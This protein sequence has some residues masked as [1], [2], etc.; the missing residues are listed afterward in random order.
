MLACVR[1]CVTAAVLG[2][3]IGLSGTS[4]A[5]EEE[6]MAVSPETT[7]QG[8]FFVGKGGDLGE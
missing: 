8:A 2:I 3:G 6:G 5:D 7:G 1:I 4:Y